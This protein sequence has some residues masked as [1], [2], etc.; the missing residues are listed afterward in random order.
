M[1]IEEAPSAQRQF[2]AGEETCTTV[3]LAISDATGVDAVGL[4]PLYE[5]V[6][7]DSVNRLFGQRAQSD[8]DQ[9][10]QLVLQVNDCWV[11]VHADGR[12]AAAARAEKPGKPYHRQSEVC[13][14]EHDWAGDH[15]L[16]VS[17]VR[18]IESLST[19]RDSN[20]VERLSETI[21]QDALCR[22]FEPVDDQSPRDT[23]WLSFLFNGYTVTVEA[24]G[25]I[26]A[27]T[28]TVDTE[29]GSA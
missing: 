21:D 17:L 2:E 3:A 28:D 12:V 27:S 23:G 15:D 16:C 13:Q 7:P 22:L 8:G 24:T 20:A 6:D 14:I 1:A 18:A 9:E 25:R 11:Q 10:K 29:V 5:F 26:T 19:Q 4:P